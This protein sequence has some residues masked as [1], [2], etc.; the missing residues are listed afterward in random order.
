MKKGIILSLRNL[1][2]LFLFMGILLSF[3]V[4]PTPSLS[5]KKSKAVI[6]DDSTKVIF[7]NWIN[8]MQGFCVYLNDDDLVEMTVNIVTQ[9][10]HINEFPD[11][12]YGYSFNNALE[13][14]SNQL[15]SSDF[16]YQEYEGQMVYIATFTHF[17]DYSNQCTTPETTL[18]IDYSL[19][20][21]TPDGNGGYNLYPVQEHL[22]TLFPVTTELGLNGNSA[23][24]EMG[25]KVVC[26]DQKGKDLGFEARQV[27][28]KPGLSQVQITPNPFSEELSIE[29]TLPHNTTAL[30]RIFDVT[31]K[32]WHQEQT[33][34]SAGRTTKQIISTAHFPP[35]LYF[36]KVNEET[37]IKL[38]KTE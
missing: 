38:L 17:M 12:H 36:Y 32:V 30:V 3:S 15:V 33:L 37:P 11:I 35:G 23:G 6:K 14:M 19:R 2:L 13:Q 16:V 4:A 26:C 18:S 10:S 29:T 22:G 25:D 8:E 34:I 20:L 28:P 24:L 27:A 5:A 21:I 1:S 31:G 9:T 7:S